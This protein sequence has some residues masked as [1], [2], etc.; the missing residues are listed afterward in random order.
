MN[1][2]NHVAGSTC[3]HHSGFDGKRHPDA[4]AVTSGWRV[5]SRTGQ[6][7]GDTRLAAHILLL[8]EF[9]LSLILEDQA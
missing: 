9:L 3:E 6:L 7:P 2:R 8:D 1:G 4:H 5:Y